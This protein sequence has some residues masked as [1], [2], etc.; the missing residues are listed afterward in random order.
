MSNPQF[1]DISPYFKVQEFVPK[2]TFQKWGAKSIRFMN[3]QAILLAQFTRSRFNRGV[4][5]NN[6]HSG[7]VYQFSGYRPPDCAEGSFESGHKR[8]L[9]IDVRVSGLSPEYVYQDILDNYPLWREAGLTTVE[10]IS[11]T[12]GSI[13]NDLGGWNHLSVE[14]TGE[15]ELTIVKP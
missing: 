1:K 11:I 7:G 12:T 5:I 3:P 6:W 13:A 15:Q 9:C 2:A 10:D 8:G 4:T 14:W